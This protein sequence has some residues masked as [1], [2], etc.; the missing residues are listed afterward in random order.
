MR[1]LFGLTLA[2]AAVTGFIAGT[3]WTEDIQVGVT[4]F[5]KSGMSERVLS[6]MKDKLNEIAPAIKVEYQEALENEEA[7]AAVVDRFQKEKAGMVIMRSGGA[8]WLAKNPPSIPT[9]IGACNHPAQLG[10]VK[11]LEAPEGNIT[12]VTYF[13][14]RET[15]FEIFKLLISDMD[16]LFLLTEEGHPSSDIDEAET[17]AL[18]T[19][20]G[21]KYNGKKCSSVDDVL[22]AI[23]ANKD[24]VSVFIIGSQNLLME[25]TDKFTAKYPDEIF[26]AYSSEPVKSGALGGFVAD[27]YKLGVFLAQSMADV[28]VNGKQVS[29]V[30]V[31]VDP[32]PKF[33][34]N[35]KVAER[36]GISIPYEILEAATVIEE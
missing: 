11:N 4:Y 23:D 13:L 6:G 22:A 32:D 35:V 36:L 31:K 28:L 5:G 9:F 21:L 30:P 16:S 7:F 3:A 2:V 17:K 18:C 34:V 26:L 15:Q 29:E 1:K 25:N 20:M 24:S 19:K 14:P 12:G 8:E 27:D 33:F 10:A